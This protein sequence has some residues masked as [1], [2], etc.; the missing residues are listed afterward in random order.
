MVPV[1][2]AQT[3][4]L[5]PLNRHYRSPPSEATVMATT[6]IRDLPPEII[7]KVFLAFLGPRSS[8]RGGVEDLLRRRRPVLLTH[9]CRQWRTHA[10]SYPFLWN[11]IQIHGTSELF[12]SFFERSHP[13]PVDLTV[14]ASA[15]RSCSKIAPP[16]YEKLKSL[17][18]THLRRI[19]SIAMLDMHRL[20]ICDVLAAVDG[21]ALPA[22]EALS[23]R[24]KG[25][26]DTAHD[27]HIP[28]LTHANAILSVTLSNMCI[29]CI[30]G[31]Q[32][33]TTLEL[34]T[35]PPSFDAAALR[36]L[37][38]SFPALSTLVIGDVQMA[39]EGDGPSQAEPPII[40][41]PNLKTLVVTPQAIISNISWGANV[42]QTCHPFC[43]CT[44]RNLIAENLEYL[45]VCGG[46][47]GS[48]PVASCP[49]HEAP[50]PER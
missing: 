14:R 13:L 47:I 37:I 40:N 28:F 3:K 11:D 44:L 41:A 36:D 30:P 32:T 29:S 16:L 25:L 2:R 4:R 12:L 22:L 24:G 38:E 18:E 19:H 46:Y 6:E 5:F 15:Y 33:L 48:V 23:L 26:A 50:N 39:R 21:M 8:K 34:L 31:Q 43:H 20:A 10:L 45:E 1:S 7:L 35:F 9:I 49:F 17:G 27:T 42:H